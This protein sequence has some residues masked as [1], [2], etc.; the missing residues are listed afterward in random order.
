MQKFKET[1]DSRY[2]YHA[3]FEHEMAYGFFKILSRKTASDKI[4]RDKIFIIAENLKYHKYHGG[5]ASMVYK[6][7][8]EKKNWQSY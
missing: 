6:F 4:L 7:C 8:D 2:I 5:L 1:G 3:C